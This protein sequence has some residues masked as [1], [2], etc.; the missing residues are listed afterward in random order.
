M[1]I[2][3]IMLSDISVSALAQ[4][5]TAAENMPGGNQ[6]MIA[7]GKGSTTLNSMVSQNESSGEQL[8]VMFK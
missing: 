4:N 8:Q 6:N 2:D 1:I 5:Q 7:Q 3:L